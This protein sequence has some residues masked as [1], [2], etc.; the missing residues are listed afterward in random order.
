MA[1]PRG[2]CDGSRGEAVLYDRDPCAASE[3]VPRTPSNSTGPI[4]RVPAGLD[5]PRL[6]MRVSRGYVRYLQL[7]C[8]RHRGRRAPDRRGVGQGCSQR[9]LRAMAGVRQNTDLCRTL[10]PQG[11]LWVGDQRGVLEASGRRLLRHRWAAAN[12]V[13]MPPLPRP[14]TPSCRAMR[15]CRASGW[16]AASPTEGC[17]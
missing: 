17:Y 10:S 14:R 12:S 7:P 9:G 2:Q 4:D 1:E 15:G 8:L 6:A 5:V 13:A 3:C 11:A 16:T